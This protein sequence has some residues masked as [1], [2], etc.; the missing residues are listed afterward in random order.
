LGIIAIVPN[1]FKTTAIMPNIVD[2]PILKTIIISS[3]FYNKSNSKRDTYLEGE[4]E[5]VEYE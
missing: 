4:D 2:T 5:C 3:S 1:K